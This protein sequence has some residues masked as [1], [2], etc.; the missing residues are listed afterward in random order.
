MYTP[1]HFKVN[2]AW[3]VLRANDIP[4]ML[5]KKP[6]FCYVLMD[7]ASAYVL[8]QVLAPGNEAPSEAE[9]EALFLRSWQGKNQWAQRLILTTEDEVQGVFAASAKEK[10]MRIE[11]IPISQLQPMADP[12]KQSFAETI[13]LGEA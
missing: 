1:Q 5:Q 4:L 2:E 13:H 12:L 10:G 9:V 7:A 11:V 8:G 3:T 6:Y